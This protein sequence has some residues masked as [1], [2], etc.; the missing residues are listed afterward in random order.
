MAGRSDD[1]QRC[2]L[3]T[4]HKAKP[5][6]QNPAGLCKTKNK[7]IQQYITVSTENIKELEFKVCVAVLPFVH[8]AL[9]SQGRM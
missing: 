1:L 6:P 7:Y 9:G 4:W 5:Y 8:F 2:K 3:L